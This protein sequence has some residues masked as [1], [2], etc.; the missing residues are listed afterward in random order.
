MKKLSI[1]SENCLLSRSNYG[2][3]IDEHRIDKII[4]ENLPK[5]LKEYANYP[6]AIK[7]EIDFLG[8]SGLKVSSEGYEIENE[9]SE[10]KEDA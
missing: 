9:E 5:G 3:E 2:V 1:V 6:V 8:E 10:E 7:I 4:A